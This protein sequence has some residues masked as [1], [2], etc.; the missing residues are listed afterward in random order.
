MNNLL[1]IM[2]PS[3]FRRQVDGR[4]RRQLSAH[5][6]DFCRFSELSKKK[7]KDVS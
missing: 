4:G 5:D 3:V 6:G 7:F 2:N 1:F